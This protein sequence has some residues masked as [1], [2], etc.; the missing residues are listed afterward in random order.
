MK[1]QRLLAGSILTGFGVVSQVLIEW[2]TTVEAANFALLTQ[3]IVWMT[4]ILGVGMI[5]SEFW[6]D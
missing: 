1:E 6:F 4:I 2:L 3:G 5:A